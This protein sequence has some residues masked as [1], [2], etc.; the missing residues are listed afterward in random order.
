MYKYMYIYIYMYL[1]IRWMCCA[2]ASQSR[3]ASAT[4][5]VRPVDRIFILIGLCL[6]L[7][8][9]LFLNIEIIDIWRINCVP[10]C[11][12][13][14]SRIA[15][16]ARGAKE[17]IIICTL[18]GLY[19]RIYLYLYL[20]LYIE[21]FDTRWLP[22]CQASRSR[23]ASAARGVKVARLWRSTDASRDDSYSCG[24]QWACYQ[25]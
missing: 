17:V 1:Y 11:K 12:A 24:Y 9:Y 16:A 25:R 5:E 2:Q 21:T 19:L 4:R 8:L 14:R 18:I 23:I 22:E 10:E 6:R 7:Y 3:T 15:S 13:S 20:I